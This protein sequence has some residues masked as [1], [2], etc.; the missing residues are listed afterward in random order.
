M[1]EI[2]YRANFDIPFDS[3]FSSKDGCYLYT[4]EKE[5]KST[6]RCLPPI[7]TKKYMDRFRKLAET[8]NRLAIRMHSDIEIAVDKQRRTGRIKMETRVLIVSA[9]DRTRF[10]SMKYADDYFV[11]P[12][13]IERG[14]ENGVSV[15]VSF[16]F[17]DYHKEIRRLAKL[18]S[19]PFEEEAIWE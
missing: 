9:L 12:C 1:E 10:R 2:I 19:E 8:C 3:I 11:L 17:Y 7:G 14:N 6:L 15:W 5:L 13:K 4:A 18:D 16:S